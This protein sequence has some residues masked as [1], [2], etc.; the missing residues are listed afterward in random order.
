MSQPSRRRGSG[1]G[2]CGLTRTRSHRGNR[3]KQGAR[4]AKPGAN[5]TQLSVVAGN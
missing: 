2:V 1:N 4:S 5:R 3:E